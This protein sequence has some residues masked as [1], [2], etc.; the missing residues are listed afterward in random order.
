MTR[1]WIVALLVG[2][3]AAPAAAQDHRFTISG[4]L[5]WLGGYPIGGQTATI[6]RND[7]GTTPYTL[8][9]VD[10]SMEQAPGAEL[11][12]GFALSRNLV[13]ELGGIRAKPQLAVSF[14]EDA[15]GQVTSLADEDVTQY[16][17]DGGVVWQIPRLQLGHNFRPFA[18]GGLGYLRQLF[19]GNTEVET[20]TIMYVGG[21]VRYF[22]R[23]ASTGRP[24]GARLELKTQVRTGGVDVAGK[25]RVYPVFNVFGFFGF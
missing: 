1:V 3:S 7:A 15:E 25:P 21:G 2:A 13:I 5:A 19:A 4:G 17:I 14:S 8:F 10:A 11:R 18:S 20:G 16:G 12:L 6:R 24:F 22:I 9:H 23:G